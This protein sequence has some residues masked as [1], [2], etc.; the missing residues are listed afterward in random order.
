MRLNRI[1]LL[2]GALI[3][4]TLG[5]AQGGA[6]QRLSDFGLMARNYTGNVPATDRVWYYT[7]PDGTSLPAGGGVH[8]AVSG[9]GNFLQISGQGQM[10]WGSLGS[11]EPRERSNSG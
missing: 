8:P 9:T 10:P 11:K 3:L 5:L 2:V 7:K 4:S 6:P 1:V